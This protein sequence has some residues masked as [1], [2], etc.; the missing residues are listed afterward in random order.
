MR[1]RPL[2]LEYVDEVN[3]DTCTTHHLHDVC[4]LVGVGS[5]AGRRILHC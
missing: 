3:D 5:A 4:A 1:E 2:T